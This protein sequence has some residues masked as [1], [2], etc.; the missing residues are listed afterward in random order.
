M[1]QVTD[2]PSLVQAVQDWLSRSDMTGPG[3]VDYFIQS[4]EERIYHDIL[5]Q[6]LQRG[7]QAMETVLAGTI[8]NGVLA[9]PAGYLAMKHL[10]LLAGS[11]SF[12]LERKNAEFIYTQFPNRTADDAPAYFAR[13]GQ[14]F[15][16]GPYPDS[17]Y[18]LAGIYWQRSIGLSSANPTTWMITTIPSTLLAAV[19]AGAGGYLQDSDKQQ[20]WEQQYTSKLGSYLLADR[21][22]E[23]SGSALSITVA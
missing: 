1:A 17:D 16:F 5:A 2:Y 15:I 19:L 12:E 11:N 7:T 6:N 14:N 20:Y 18:T 8:A 9:L 23:V 3:P 22:E 21:A 13:E 10:I 4:A